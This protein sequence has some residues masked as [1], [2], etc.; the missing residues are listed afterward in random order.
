MLK[1]LV[2]LAFGI[3]V[4]FSEKQ[5]PNMKMRKFYK[6]ATMSITTVDQRLSGTR[7]RP[8]QQVLK[9]NMPQIHRNPKLTCSDWPFSPCTNSALARTV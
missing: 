4:V 2:V 8:P 7:S 3:F 6:T 5:P 9:K 1:E